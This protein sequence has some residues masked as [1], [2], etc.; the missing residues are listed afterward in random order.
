MR[1]IICLIIGRVVTALARRHA[2]AV[3]GTTALV[4]MAVLVAGVQLASAPPAAALAGLERTDAVSGSMSF[5]SP[6]TVDVGCPEGKTVIGG[7]A[8]IDG[9]GDEESIAPRLT[10]VVPVIPGAFRATAETPGHVDAQEL[11]TLRVYAVCADSPVA[12]Y[13]PVVSP[14]GHYARPFLNAVARCPEGTVAYSAGGQISYLHGG[15]QGGVGLQLVRTSGPLDIARATG[16]EYPGVQHGPW[17]VIAWAICAAPSGGI[18]AEGTIAEGG[19]RSIHE[20]SGLARVHGPGGGGGTDDGGPTNLQ[21]IVPNEEL[22]H[23]SVGMTREFIPAAGP[24]AS[25]TCAE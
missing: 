10:M 18:H 17:Q 14:S 5:E 1:I 4:M 7:G 11:W 8:E 16:R 23:V 15:S 2:D 19:E 22:T 24:I 6:K 12:G 13:V 21:Y 9:G 20:C 25:A 3:V